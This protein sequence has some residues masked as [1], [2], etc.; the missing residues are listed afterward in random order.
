MNRDFDY[1][2]NYEEQLVL[3]A[4][5]NA[6]WALENICKFRSRLLKEGRYEDN[7]YLIDIADSIA[8]SYAAS[9]QHLMDIQKN[10]SYTEDGPD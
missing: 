2:T 8:S 7:S 1:C 9:S 3:V 6:N 10:K 4:A 5:E